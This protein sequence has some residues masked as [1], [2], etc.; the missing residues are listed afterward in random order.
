MQATETGIDISN[1]IADKAN[2]MIG[3]TK[4]PILESQGYFIAAANKQVQTISGVDTVVKVFGEPRNINRQSLVD[5]T[6]KL[7]AQEAE[8]LAARTQIAAV[9][10]D[11][12]AQDL[13]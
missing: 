8:I 13:L 9:L 7:D 5:L 3:I 1:Y 2:G 10:A 12:D 6:A 11:M 4:S